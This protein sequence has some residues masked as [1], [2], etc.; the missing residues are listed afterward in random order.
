MIPL[1]RREPG[2]ISTLTVEGDYRY[3]DRSEERE[4]LLDWSTSGLGQRRITT[5]YRIRL[6]EASASSTRTRLECQHTISSKFPET[7]ASSCL[8]SMSPEQ[9]LRR[10]HTGG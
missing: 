9:K 6:P 3:Y 5:L 2:R 4:S 8:S 10:N 7:T 1:L